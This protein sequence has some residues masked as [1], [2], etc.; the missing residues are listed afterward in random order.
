MGI[1]KRHCKALLAMAG[2]ILLAAAGGGNG[3][4]IWLWG[5]L[6]LALL[7]VGGKG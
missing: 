1:V 6:G 4:E 3:P 5:G 2:I 7:Y